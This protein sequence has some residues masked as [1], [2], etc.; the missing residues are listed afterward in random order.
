MRRG[1]GRA[2]DLDTHIARVTSTLGPALTKMQGV[3]LL[4]LEVGTELP[5]WTFACHAA[6][7]DH[8]EAVRSG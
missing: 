2:A 7:G 8:A 6:G 1:V 5:S 3:R 4:S